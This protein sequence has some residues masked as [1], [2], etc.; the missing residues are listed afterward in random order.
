[1][2]THTHV[3][4]PGGEFRDPER[5]AVFQAEHL[6]ERLRQAR[7]AFFWAFLLNLLFYVSDWRFFDQ[8]HF[9]AAMTARS[10]IVLA[11]L[12]CLAAASRVR[13]FRGLQVLCLAW[14]AAT[15]PACAVLLAPHTEAALFMLFVLPII[16]SQI[17]PLGFGPALAVSLLGS[18]VILTGYLSGRTAQPWDPALGLG[19]LTENTLLLLLL[20]RSNRLQRQEWAARRAERQANQEL[21]EGRRMLHALLQAVPAPLLV[22]SREGR[23][24]QANAAAQSYFGETALADPEALRECF[25]PEDYAR[26]TTPEPHGRTSEFEAQ[27]RLADGSTRDVLL[28]VSTAALQGAAHSLAVFVDISRR[29]EMEARLAELANTDPLTGLANRTRF[30]DA[31]GTEIRRAQ[32]RGP[33]PAVIMLDIDHFK[34]INDSCGH[35]AGDLALRRVAMLCRTLLRCQD[36]AARL[37]GEEFALL[38]PETDRHGALALAERL[39]LA[40]EGLRLDGPASMTV[41]LGIAEVQPGENTV[42]AALVRADKAMYAAKRAGRNRSVC[43]GS[44]IYA[45]NEG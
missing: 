25:G 10:A 18:A 19:L 5:E 23:I 15:I 12:G 1:M 8:A 6:P 32:R 38:L 45:R 26:I 40:V 11:S 17:L 20:V 31:A 34:R 43:H 30:F 14:C 9:L 3:L 41:S 33:L 27:V 37:G 35:E 16:F 22:L 2:T 36:L 29:K 4:T 7:L 21:A 13:G 24:V 42:N 44:G 39:R 28:N